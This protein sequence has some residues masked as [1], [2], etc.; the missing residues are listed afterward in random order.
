MTL[1]H[2]IPGALGGTQTTLTCKRCN[3]RHGTDLDAHFVRMIEARKWAS[4]N[5]SKQLKGK[6]GIGSVEVPV[7]ILWGAGDSPCT[8]AIPGASFEKLD[9]LNAFLHSVEQGDLLKFSVDLNY[10]PSRTQR[11][12]VRIAYLS[13]FETCG[14]GYVLSS[15][16]VFVR[17]L[18]DGHHDDDLALFMLA[19][20]SDDDKAIGNPIVTIPIGT[21]GYLVIVRIDAVKP[22]LHL[23]VT[24]PF[25]HLKEDRLRS[26]LS[27]LLDVFDGKQ[28]R[29]SVPE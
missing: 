6:L 2:I 3:N 20:H 10:I 4:G 27:D 7:K 24:M 8:M 11:A 18:I 21:L 26:A 25:A 9:R 13:L 14:Y 5:D 28:F 17:S 29:I 22:A 1:E 12:L 23:G 15:A 19:L 16:G